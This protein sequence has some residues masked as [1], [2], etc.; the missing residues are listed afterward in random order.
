MTRLVLDANG[1]PGVVPSGDIEDMRRHYRNYKQIIKAQTVA[2]KPGQTVRIIDG[3]F[4]GY[5]AEVE[6]VD[7]LCQGMFRAIADIM[8]RRVPMDIP[9]EIIEAVRA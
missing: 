8:G 6:S 2:L 4:A 7:K 1:E 5:N 9:T 3:P